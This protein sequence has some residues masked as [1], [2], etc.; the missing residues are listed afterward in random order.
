MSTGKNPPRFRG[1]FIG[2]VQIYGQQSILLCA[3]SGNVIVGQ[4]LRLPYN[5]PLQ[6]LA[7][8]AS[9]GIGFTRP[10]RNSS[11]RRF[12]KAAHCL[13]TLGLDGF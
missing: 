10:E 5:L 12:A 6:I 3:Y 7:N 9:P 13:S 2:G 1:G 11:S 4:A 8:T